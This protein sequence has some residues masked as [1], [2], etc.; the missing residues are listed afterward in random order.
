MSWEKLNEM[1]ISFIIIIIL[2]TRQMQN[3]WNAILT[4]LQQY[5]H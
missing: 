3:K 4:F 1:L 2:S 5:C